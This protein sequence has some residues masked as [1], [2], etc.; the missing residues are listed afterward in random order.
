MW[1]NFNNNYQQKSLDMKK[2]IFTI[3]ISGACLSASADI[4]N[5]PSIVSFQGDHDESVEYQTWESSYCYGSDS[6]TPS[7]REEVTAR[8]ESGRVTTINY[9]QYDS[10][11]Q[12][13]VFKYTITYSYNSSG[14]IIKQ[15]N[16][17][18]SSIDKYEYT[19][20]ENGNLTHYLNSEQEI[21]SESV[22]TCYVEDRTYD[23][24]GRLST[25]DDYCYYHVD[26]L[27]DA[28]YHY[29]LSYNESGLVSKIERFDSK[30]TEGNWVISRQYN[31]E[32]DTKG[33]VT[34]CVYNQKNDDSG[35]L[36][37][38][39]TYTFTYND[40]GDMLTQKYLYESGMEFN[41]SYT[42][43]YDDKGRLTSYTDS[44]IMGSTKTVY[45]YQDSA[46]SIQEQIVTKP[47]TYKAL[48]NGHIVIVSGN[49]KYNITGQK[50][51]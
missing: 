20:D 21:G 4:H 46:T 11:N 2:L 49:E 47:R 18:N 39:M 37:K 42:Y 51:K 30:D 9:L 34:T 8:D 6:F 44:S 40:H 19:Y 7:S 36:E 17:D 28:H 31:Y 43:T 48:E 5:L 41:Y 12:K 1:N 32:Y 15:E 14:K 50:S 16:K 45:T 22:D 27:D 13:F 26:Y 25:V 38:Y 33:L 29:T 24:S 3:I 35:V 23:A 10:D